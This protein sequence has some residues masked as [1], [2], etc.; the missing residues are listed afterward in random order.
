MITRATMGIAKG[1]WKAR[2]DSNSS[3]ESEGWCG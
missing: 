1:V 3:D 2:D